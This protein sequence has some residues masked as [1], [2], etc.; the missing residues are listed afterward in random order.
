MIS[1]KSSWVDSFFKKTVPQHQKSSDHEKTLQEMM[2]WLRKIEQSTESISARLAAVEQRLSL[3]TRLSHPQW[4][5]NNETNEKTK[6]S[7]SSVSSENMVNSEINKDMFLKELAAMQSLL[8]D[9]QEKIVSLENKTMKMKTKE[10]T[11]QQSLD[12]LTEHINHIKNNVENLQKRQL[13]RSF[14]MKVKGREIPIEIS[15]IIGGVLAFIV[16]ILIGIGGKNIVVSPIFLAAIGCVLIGSSLF[17]SA[18]LGILI[19]HLVT[20]SSQSRSKNDY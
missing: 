2:I 1:S 15:G 14:S 19:K 11:F 6:L 7:A 9:Q 8:T 12:Q 10:T 13:K 3:K 5:I 16:A 20:K 18:H 4:F 17:R